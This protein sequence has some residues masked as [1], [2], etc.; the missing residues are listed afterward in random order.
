MLYARF[1]EKN[2]ENIILLGETTSMMVDRK[3][4]S[5]AIP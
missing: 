2:A 5:I 4:L 3:L 1:V